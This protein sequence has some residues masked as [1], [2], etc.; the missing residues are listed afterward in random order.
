MLQLPPVKHDFLFIQVTNEKLVKYV[1]GMSPC[2]L[3]NLFDYDEFTINQR[4]K[5]DKQYCEL[6]SRIRLG[7]ASNDDIKILNYR[8]MVFQA[9][10]LKY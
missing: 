7:W 9:V 3:W 4:Q 5:N 10:F 1:G 8:K 6:L 2:D